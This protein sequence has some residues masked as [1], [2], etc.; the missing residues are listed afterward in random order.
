MAANAK[1]AEH[2]RADRIGAVDRGCL[3]GSV[4]RAL[5]GV[6]LGMAALAAAL[7]SDS[8]QPADRAITQYLAL[9]DTDRR[10]MLLYLQASKQIPE[11][12]Q[13]AIAEE[14]CAINRNTRRVCATSGRAK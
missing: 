1:E 11:T 4:M 8:R 12:S 6:M 7:H 14:W 13:R 3:A 2:A 5:I 10:D 9:P